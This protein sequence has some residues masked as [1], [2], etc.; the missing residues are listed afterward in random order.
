MMCTDAVLSAN[1]DTPDCATASKLSFVAVTVYVSGISETNEKCPVVS[2]VVDTISD[3]DD[4]V[5]FAPESGEPSCSVTTPLSAPV[6]PASSNVPWP[7]SIQS[8]A[9]AAIASNLCFANIKKPPWVGEEY[10]RMCILFAAVTYSRTKRR[11]G[12]K[13]AERLR[14]P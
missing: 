1:T 3:G 10:Q 12:S 5:T 6:V 4:A 8:A 13:A 14:L 11:A 2:V 7:N 9:N